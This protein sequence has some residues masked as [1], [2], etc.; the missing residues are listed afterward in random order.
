MSRVRYRKELLNC[1]DCGYRPQSAFSLSSYCR[2][3][4]DKAGNKNH[5][6]RIDVDKLALLVGLEMAIVLVREC[7]A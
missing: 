4:D 5:E 1:S 6:P 2:A 3:C 7:E